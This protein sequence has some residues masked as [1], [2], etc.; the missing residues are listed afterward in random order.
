M[1]TLAELIA[2]M[3]D[4]A[5]ATT[6]EV[7]A[8]LDES[9]AVLG[10]ATANT[11]S[12]WAAQ[13]GMRVR[14]E[15]GISANES[16]TVRGLALTARDLLWRDNGIDLGDPRVGPLLDAMESATLQDAAPLLS[17][18]NRA[19]LEAAATKQVKR[20][21]L[22]SD[23]DWTKDEPVGNARRLYDIARARG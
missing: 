7:D 12:A 23:C 1:P 10:H 17:S 11:L 13:T 2:L 20:W 9:V 22:A 5:T 8:W 15:D 3:P 14:L 16:V 6:A 18:T 21:T 19:A 4:E